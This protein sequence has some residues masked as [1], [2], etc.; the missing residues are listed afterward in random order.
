MKKI[1][2]SAIISFIAFG[3]YPQHPAEKPC[4]DSKK[5]CCDSVAP[6]DR[7][8]ILTYLDKIKEAYVNQD[9]GFL[10]SILDVDQSAMTDL[11]NEFM[12]EEILDAAIDDITVCSDSN[13]KKS[14]KSSFKLSRKGYNFS[15]NKY[16]SILWDFSDP[17]HPK[18]VDVTTENID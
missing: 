4:C 2:L 12:D 6:N 7:A 1:I 14:F 17:N 5:A 3:A 10:M 8:I 13:Q 15:D 9:Q 11:Y 18:I 16:V